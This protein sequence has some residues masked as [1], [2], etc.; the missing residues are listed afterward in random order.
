MKILIVFIA[1]IA[2]VLP[3]PLTA[4]VCRVQRVV[5]PVYSYQYS[6]AQPVVLKQVYPNYYY[7]VGTDLQLDALAERLSAR[8]EAKLIER[9]RA[10]EPQER[11]SIVTASCAKCHSPGS[12][13]V[14]EAEAPVFF[15]AAG[16]LTATAEQRASM[17]TAAKFGAMPPPPAKEMSDD[18]YIEFRRELERVT[19]QQRE[20]VPP[21]PPEPPTE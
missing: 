19:E 5:T 16:N 6:Y 21:P 9:Q 15:D 13:A 11:Q 17:K 2:S 4:G 3:W 1:I 12:K 20:R 8:I 18:D 7:S 14:K 10:H